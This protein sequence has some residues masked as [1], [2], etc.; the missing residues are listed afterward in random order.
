MTLNAYDDLAICNLA[1][2]VL[3]LDPIN[4][5]EVPTTDAEAKLARLYPITMSGLLSR[6]DWNFADGYVQLAVNADMAPVSG[7]LRAFKLPSAMIAGPFAIYDGQDLARPVHDYLNHADHIHTDRTDVWARYRK[8]VPVNL[9]PEYFV[10][11]A[12]VALAYVAAKP[13]T[14][15]TSMTTELR[16]R[17]YGPAELD[18][19]GG[20]WKSAKGIDAKSQPVRSIFQN[21]D[22]L[23]RLVR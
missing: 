13:L 3:G 23:T 2:D 7:Y 14:D 19:E 10:E 21:G 12:Y 16:I 1:C 5:I 17:T 6:H 4:S 20:L 11:L 22:P 9:W 18:G 8:K 15:N